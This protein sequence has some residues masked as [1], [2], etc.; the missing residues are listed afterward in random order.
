MGSR[1][2]KRGENFDLCAADFEKLNDPEEQRKYFRVDTPTKLSDWNTTTSG[3]NRETLSLTNLS[4]NRTNGELDDC[5][6]LLF[7]GCTLI[8]LH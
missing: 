7:R 6:P 2:H 4:A 5:V 1:Y 8:L 3:N